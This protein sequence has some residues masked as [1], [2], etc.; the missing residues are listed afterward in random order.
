MKK[1]FLLIS[2][3]LLFVAACNLVLPQ[4]ESTSIPAQ[5]LP[6]TQ[7]GSQGQNS[8]PRTEAEVPR[9]TLENA[10]VAFDNRTAVFVDVRSPDAF[11][12]EHI[13][14]AISIPLSLAESDASALDLDKEQWI[15]TYCT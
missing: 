12:A 10:K 8:F 2:I 4:T 9:I 7:E 6:A 1:S 13:T 3:M 5:S 11:A 14:G 15:I